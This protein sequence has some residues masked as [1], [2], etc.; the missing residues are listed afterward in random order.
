[1]RVPR[2]DNAARFVHD[3]A[4]PAASPSGTMHAMRRLSAS[5]VGSISC[6]SLTLVFGACAPE[7]DQGECSSTRPCSARGE[8]CDVAARECVDAEV[9]VDQTAEADADGAFG[10]LALPFFRGEVCVATAVKPGEAIPMSLSP[11]VHPCVSSTAYKVKHMF[12]CVGSSCEGAM[13]MWIGD[14]AGAA[15]PADVFARFDAS[16]CVYPYTVGAALGPVTLDSGPVEGSIAVEVPFLSNADATRIAGG[17][18]TADNWAMIKAYPAEEE[19]SFRVTLSP[20][21]SSAP[22]SCLD[23][24]KSKC[25]CR[26][27]GL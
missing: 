9:D 25:E 11:C 16:Q 19:R 7:V 26:M 22:E 10:P 6:I 4:D 8:V 20:A 15:C 23:A 5:I 1:M 12:S 3:S 2:Y 18:S 21:S 27:L 14:A 17:S 13:L 24:D